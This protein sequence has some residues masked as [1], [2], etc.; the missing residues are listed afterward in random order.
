VDNDK[1]DERTEGEAT[2]KDKGKDLDALRARLGLKDTKK[3]A[4]EDGAGL[5]AGG[6]ASAEPEKPGAGD[7]TLDF[8][9]GGKAISSV[10]IEDLDAGKVTKPKGRLI[11]ISI[12][13]LIA[14]GTAL[15]LGMQFGRDLGLRSLHNAGV[16]QAKTLRTYF[17]EPQTDP[18]GQKLAA[19]VEAI[20]KFR[21]EYIVWYNENINALSNLIPVLETG[22]PAMLAQ[23]GEYAEVQKQL[24]LIKPLIK[25]LDKVDTGV[26]DMN[27]H[28]IFGDRVFHPEIAYKVV[29]YMAAA[30][31]LQRTLDDLRDALTLLYGFQ[32]SPE[33]PTG[34]QTDLTIWAPRKD[35]Q[36]GVKGA[37]VELSGKPE[38]KKEVEDKHSYQ[39]FKEMFNQDLDIKVPK[40]EEVPE[41]EDPFDSY[42]VE[43]IIG[44]ILKEA[45]I[46]GFIVAPQIHMKITEQEVKRWHEV[47]VRR[48]AAGGDKKTAKVADLIQLN[49]RAVMEP[50]VTRIYAQYSVEMVNRA[51]IV[52]EIVENL[53]RIKDFS[54]AASPENLQKFLD[55]LAKQET[56][57]TF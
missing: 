21:D 3:P 49:I 40:C 37:L 25:I 17:F 55:D 24:E 7:F 5:T 19:R 43:K 53:D 48:Y 33:P 44:D 11:V 20:Q 56:Y 1:T 46:K 28:G 14:L 30:N 42:L 36:E 13:A 50:I 41:G 45:E 27:P 6:T 54:L 34:I 31:R 10:S 12:A 39:T 35:G 29:D 52:A 16:T 38:E 51:V 4:A 57:T 18:T 9:A 15:W 32:W 2:S 23:L 47:K 26:A 8:G 22:D